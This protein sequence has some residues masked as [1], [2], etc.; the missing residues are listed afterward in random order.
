MSSNQFNRLKTLL[1]LRLAGGYVIV[2]QYV[3]LYS[4]KAVPQ[5]NLQPLVPY[6]SLVNY[7]PCRMIV[8]T[9]F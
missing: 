3:T 4:V 8:E 2:V 7:L 1:S 6:C 5:A 9:H